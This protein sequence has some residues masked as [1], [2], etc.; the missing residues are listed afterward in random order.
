MA[1]MLLADL[2]SNPNYKCITNVTLAITSGTKLLLQ[3]DDFVH[4]NYA[5]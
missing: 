5:H 1:P 3:I 2:S 4:N